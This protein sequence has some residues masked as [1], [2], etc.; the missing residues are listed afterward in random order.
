MRL[1]QGLREACS[2]AGCRVAGRWVR[3]PDRWPATAPT[4]PTHP[5]PQELLGPLAA[6]EMPLVRV[7]VDMEAAGLG[8]NE[9]ILNTGGW[10]GRRAAVGG[11]VARSA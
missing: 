4:H 1:Q 2:G 9:A 11:W 10:V 6:T 7:I 8:V 5:A 3:L